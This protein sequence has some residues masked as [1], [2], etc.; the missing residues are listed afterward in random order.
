MPFAS[1]TSDYFGIGCLKVIWKP[2]KCNKIYKLSE[3]S[4]DSD[5]FKKS[6]NKV[7]WHRTNVA[8]KEVEISGFMAKCHSILRT[9][10]Y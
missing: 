9:L 2:F 4:E 6:G 7:L 8:C 1:V 5:F 10:Y 3:I